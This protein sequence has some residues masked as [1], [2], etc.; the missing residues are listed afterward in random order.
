M[1][2]GN[3]LCSIIFILFIIILWAMALKI[4][5]SGLC[6]LVK[7]MGASFHIVPGANDTVEL[8][9]FPEVAVSPFLPAH[10]QRYPFCL[11]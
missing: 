3:F 2:I 11:D 5:F 6:G 4:G 10:Q 8:R 1:L 9:P 7:K